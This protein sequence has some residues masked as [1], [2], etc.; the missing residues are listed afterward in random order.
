MKCIDGSIATLRKR[1]TLRQV[2]RSLARTIGLH[3]A[4]PLLGSA[5]EGRIF[6]PY[7]WQISAFLD[8]ANSNCNI[9][10]MDEQ[11]RV[12]RQSTTS[13]RD[14]LSGRFPDCLRELAIPGPEAV[15]AFQ[16]VTDDRGRPRCATV[17]LPTL[18]G[19]TL[20]LTVTPLRHGY[21]GAISHNVTAI[22]R[23]ERDAIDA[24]VRAES[25]NRAMTEM[26]AMASHEL[27]THA[28]AVASMSELLGEAFPDNQRRDCAKAIISSS[29]A[30]TRIA[31]DVIDVSKLEAEKLDIR[32][33]PFDLR[34]LVTEITTVFAVEAKKKALLLTCS[35]ADKLPQTVI[36][37]EVR[38]RQ[39]V[40]NLLA[41][42]IK[43]TKIGV[44][45][46]SVDVLSIDDMVDVALTI[47]DSGPGVPAEEG[48]A[49]FAAYTRLTPTAMTDGSG[50]GLHISRK[51]AT[52]MGGQLAMA[53]RTDVGAAFVLTLS[54]GK[55][56]RATDDGFDGLYCA[57][58]TSGSVCDAKGETKLAD[59][60]SIRR[61]LIVDD[62]TTNRLIFTSFLKGHGEIEIATAVDGHD[63]VAKHRATRPEIILMDLTMP[64]MDGCTAAAHIRAH[65]A[66]T[67]TARCTIIALT[68]HA[69]RGDRDRCI[70]AGM[71]DFLTK[72]ITKR[73]LVDCLDTWRLSGTRPE[74]RHYCG[75]E[76]RKPD[77]TSG[78]V[79][80]RMPVGRLNE[81]R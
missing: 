16:E 39:I 46:V 42:A 38:I 54:L 11:G 25:T 63:A 7:N 27:R 12:I 77:R 1:R 71:D 66:A 64:D 47:A 80:D 22:K 9:I 53:P 21:W 3:R 59:R 36:G 26:L 23:S 31:D 73:A 61:V 14:P 37:D 57:L 44:V 55:V 45:S 2:L 68:A 32:L 15:A 18:S 48:D 81:G 5:L 6:W 17:I 49:I 56:A 20:Q 62:N 65:E 40:T 70:A 67:G 58:T 4:L 74:Q 19:E 75:P 60:T 41:N 79:R 24:R 33:S 13:A 43:F 35:I 30:L 72:P 28:N 51:L 52:R 34:A 76:R 50:L 29:R 10:I 8:V 69:I 78:S